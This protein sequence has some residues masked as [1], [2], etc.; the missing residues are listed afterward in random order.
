MNAPTRK[1]LLEDV[2]GFLRR[3]IAS[4]LKIEKADY[5]A[6]L[7]TQTAVNIKGSDLIVSKRVADLKI[8]PELQNDFCME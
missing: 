1:E 6:S 8:E 5:D 7:D 2:K 4:T 3:S